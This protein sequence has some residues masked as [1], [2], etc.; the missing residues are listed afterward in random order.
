MLV[1]EVN[2]TLAEIRAWAYSGSVEPM[3]DWDIIVA[4]LP[5][6]ELLLDLVG[7]QA[8]PA[9]GFLLG[10]LYCVVGHSDRNDPQLPSAVTAAEASTEVWLRTR[11]RR[12]RQVLADPSD[13]RRDDWCGWQGFRRDP[14]G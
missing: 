9:R 8:C 7:D 3:Q 1:D 2:P 11:G 14:A 12:V 6:L 10:S 13:F 4:D 5:N